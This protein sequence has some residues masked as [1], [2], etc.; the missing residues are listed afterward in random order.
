[1]ISD[2]IGTNNRV[3][4]NNLIRQLFFYFFSINVDY[5]KKIIL[6]TFFRNLKKNKLI[7]IKRNLFNDLKKQILDFEITDEIL[8]IGQP[9]IEIK[10]MDRNQYFKYLK[11]IKRLFPNFKYVPSRKENTDN[12][13]YIK[14]T[15]NIDIL[16]TNINIELYFLINK[17][18]P[19]YIFGFTSTALL[20]LNHIYN[21]KENLINIKSIKAKFKNGRLSKEIVEI[22]YERIRYSGIQIIDYD[23][24]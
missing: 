18:L 10:L 5:P 3:L 14:D 13:K 12:L 22:Y 2:F 11:K 15:L 21:S 17:K 23:K 6:F 8:F 9:F 4:K 20:I 19:Q 24:F 16:K 1:M 7:E